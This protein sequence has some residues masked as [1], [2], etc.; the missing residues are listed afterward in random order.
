MKHYF[1]FLLLTV[2]ILLCGNV[3]PAQDN[4]RRSSAR[5]KI[6][7]A[8][9]NGQ[10]SRDAYLL[11]LLYNITDRT[12]LDKQ[13]QEDIA[14]VEKCGTSIALHLRS[15]KESASPFVQTEIGKF[16]ARPSKQKF[17]DTPG[18]KFR[19]NYDT[20]GTHAVYQPTVDVNPQ[21]GV[22]D[23]VDRTGE[24]FDRVWKF[25]IDTLGYDA[26]APDGSAGGGSNR[27]DIYLHK[28]SGAYGVTY[29]ETFISG[30]LGRG[31]WSSYI[32]V[33]PAYEGFGYP[34][35]TMPMKVTAAHE[36]HHAVQFVYNA[37]AG[38]WLMEIT[39]TWMEDIAYDAINDYYLYLND[40]TGMF[41]QP[42]LS[43]E[44]ENGA[45]EYSACLFDHY[46]S[47][48]YGV[49]AVRKIWEK[50]IGAV[51]AAIAADSALAAYGT[52]L[53]DV[54]AG[55]CVWNY[56]TGSRAN[57]SHP[58]YSEATSYPQTKLHRR[59][60]AL[61]FDSTNEALPQI[62]HLGAYNLK[63]IGSHQTGTFELHFDDISG[64]LYKGKII[65]DSAR[66]YKS[67]NVDLSVGASISNWQN[68]DS[69][70]FIPA[71]VDAYG[72]GFFFGYGGTFTPSGVS[73]NGG[74]PK[75]F[76]LQQNYPN[77]FNPSTIIHYTLAQES[78]V[79]LTVFNLAGQEI[80][81][82]R[83][84]KNPAGEYAIRWEPQGLSSGVY[85]YK[86]QTEYF[87]DVKKM[88]LMK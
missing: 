33:D 1:Y 53:A 14:G 2:C 10:L 31:G 41:Q 65:R 12:Q 78:S 40:G 55:Y 56:F 38:A 79:Q 49:N 44:T 48:N 37:N 18:G 11:H 66:N 57:N 24:I 19:I 29:T 54:Y 21:N 69:I 64:S 73:E 86:L 6:E 23:Y 5:G 61:P 67:M 75:E 60:I 4:I 72:A 15:E 58:H 85:F 25:E 62:Q 77:P 17:F 51:P 74:V 27:Y 71:N 88:I 82:L 68:V 30:Y 32:H 20:T 16:L 43:L 8:H 9:S 63:I 70:I 26:P 34:D 39:A 83:N 3:L 80:A 52:T 35:R 76:L 28:N 13:F 84:E 42:N 50:T 46:I 22:P 7:D 59:I 47:E 45:H 87:T 36:F 81:T